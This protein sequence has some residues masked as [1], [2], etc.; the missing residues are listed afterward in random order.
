MVLGGHAQTIAGTFLG[1]AGPYRATQHVV[2]LSD[3]DKIVLHDDTPAEWD[4][5]SGTIALLVHGLAGCHG[6]GYMSR[7]AAKLVASGARAFRMDQRGSGAGMGLAS[8]A[9]NGARSDDIASALSYIRDR[10]PTATI[11]LVGFSLGA[12]MSLKLATEHADELDANQ[13]LAIAPPLDFSK[14]SR[15]IDTGVN[16]G[17]SRYFARLLV[18]HVFNNPKLRSQLSPKLIARPPRTLAEFDERITAPLGGFRDLD[19][20]YSAASPLPVL[21]RINV[22]TLIITA[23]D[24]PL[25]PFED[26]SRAKLS[27]STQV[28]ATDHGGH[29]G[30][31]ANRRKT[32]DPDWHWMD[33]R[34]VDTVRAL[35]D[36]PMNRLA[37]TPAIGT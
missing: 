22:P 34:V 32:A 25:V 37:R 9:N 23:K 5:T 11:T 27:K 2:G 3:G 10:F 14:C 7:I 36:V 6:S 28:L 4:S 31:L 26:F 21:H 12:A 19:D 33:W 13:V 18:R 20:Y 16:R 35:I 30:F 1:K 29:M 15:S 17:Y 24:D 8:Y